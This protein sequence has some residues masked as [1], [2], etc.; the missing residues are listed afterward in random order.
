MSL[1]KSRKTTFKIK[2]YEGSGGVH[3]V[4][5]PIVSP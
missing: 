4:L 5:E 1:Y 2:L 3:D